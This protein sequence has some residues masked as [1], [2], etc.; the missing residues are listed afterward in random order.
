MV[1]GNESS[2]IWD[3]RPE[4]MISPAHTYDFNHG[5]L[6]DVGKEFLLAEFPILLILIGWS[7]HLS[8]A[9]IA[10][11]R[12]DHPG[13]Q[14]QWIANA[15]HY[16]ICSFCTHDKQFLPC[17]GKAMVPVPSSLKSLA[18]YFSLGLS[19]PGAWLSSPCRL[20]K[21][22]PLSRSL[23]PWYP[24]LASSPVS[25]CPEQLLPS[26]RSFCI[27]CFMTLSTQV[28][29]ARFSCAHPWALLPGLM[30]SFWW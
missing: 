17:T 4:T 29:H 23:P 14:Q 5:N 24:F 10:S 11:R 7:Q 8:S 3:W 1:N 20:S 19:S 27:L 22:R 12:P 26:P 2:R 15:A 18:L 9:R 13:K 16:H 21:D 28:L 30:V 25:L 6:V